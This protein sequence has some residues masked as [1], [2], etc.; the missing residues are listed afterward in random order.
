M[1]NLDPALGGRV[2]AAWL[3]LEDVCVA[4]AGAEQATA[5]AGL[6]CELL[7]L[8]G[9][10]TPAEIEGLQAARRLYHAAGVD[11]TRTRPSSEALLRRVLKGQGLPAVNNAVDAG[12][13]LSL[14]TLLPLG[15]YDAGRIEGA[16]ELRRG[17]PG[18]SYPGIRKEEVH[19]EG[20]L[21]LFDAAGPFGSPTSD[22]PRTAVT[23]ASRR[24]LLVLFA[25]GD[26]PAAR[27]DGALELGAELFGRWCGARPG[28]SGRLA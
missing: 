24:L 1:I 5:F 26:L 6:E 11:P 8:Y 16:V 22:S 15:L 3:E 25:P 23:E 2:A 7:S 27:L 4:P 20:R 13:E 19:L 21:G 14:R 12:N 18:E 17:R 9:G 10:R 28:R